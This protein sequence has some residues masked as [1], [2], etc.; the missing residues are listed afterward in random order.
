MKKKNLSAKKKIHNF[1]I[2]KLNE[3][4]I[5]RI[6]LNFKKKLSN[7]NHNNF[8]VSVSGGA[9]SLALSFLAKCYSIENNNKIY[10]FIVDH[11]LR[12]NSTLEARTVKRKLNSFDIKTDILTVRKVKKTSNLQSF[13][14]ENRYRL[15]IKRCLNKKIDTIL[16][17]H[18]KDDLFENF[19]IRLLRGSG[20]RGLSSFGNVESKIK[21]DDK[22]FIFRPLLDVSKNDLNYIT[23]NTFNF[24]IDD[25][26]NYNLNFLRV[27]VRSL[28]SKLED[29]GLT[30]N[31][32]KKTLNNLNKS[33][34]AIDYYVKKNIND[35]SNYITFS[36]TIILN[37][38]FLKQPDEVVFRSFSEV[39]QKMGKKSSY[40]RGVKVENLINFIRSSKS[41]KKKTLS[42][43]IIQKIDKS[44]IIYPENK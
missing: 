31:K 6:Y 42:G 16:T 13:A 40:S 43:C 8:C 32:F 21:Y 22:V 29:D 39:I 44:V 35:N 12:K 28:I 15:I 4:R 19:F 34:F 25:P 5:R 7:Y 11:K 30:F 20:L 33:N 14:R 17:A 1:Y 2:K 9:D 23:K 18:H 41:N 38:N 36:K 37:E 27:K 26:S 24:K 10:F 3:P